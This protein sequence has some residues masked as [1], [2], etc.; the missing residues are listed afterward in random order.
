MLTTAAMA[1]PMV[2]AGAAQAPPVRARLPPQRLRPRLQHRGPSGL[3]H[4]GLL[5]A[6]RPQHLREHH[7]LQHHRSQHCPTIALDITPTIAGTVRGSTAKPSSYADANGA[8]PAA[9]PDSAASSHSA[10][11]ATGVYSTSTTGATDVYSTST[12][13]CTH[14]HAT[15][16][17]KWAI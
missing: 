13:T 10:T 7:R 17:A 5:G 16:A 4:R 1:A 8:A 11:G 15:A 6:T 12:S 3:R 9:A 2:L 14:A